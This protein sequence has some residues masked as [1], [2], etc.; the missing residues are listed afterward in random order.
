MSDATLQ[1][2]GLETRNLTSRPVPPCPTQDTGE[3]RHAIMAAKSAGV[4]G[5]VGGGMAGV[6]AARALSRKGQ[7]GTV[8]Y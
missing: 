7:P 8:T 5:V 4:V 3:N 6:A 1:F 2:C